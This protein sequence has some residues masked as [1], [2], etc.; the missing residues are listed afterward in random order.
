MS[1]SKLIS[2]GFPFL[3]VFIALFTFSS[4][5]NE[6]EIETGLTTINLVEAYNNPALINM[7]DFASEIEYISLE[8]SEE[9]FYRWV[10]LN[11]TLG[12]SIIL[13]KSSDRISLF[14]RKTGAYLRDIGYRG[15]DPEGFTNA[16]TELG[17]NAKNKTVYAKG[18]RFDL[19]EYS[20]DEGLLI[21]KIPGPKIEALEATLNSGS[22]TDVSLITSYGIIKDGLIAG[23]FM[24]MKG[25]EPYKLVVYD[26][27]GEI[28]NLYPNYL[29]YEKQGISIR[30]EYTDFHNYNDG[31]FF[32]ENFNDTVFNVG[33]DTLKPVLLYDLGEYSPPYA[34]QES[35][36]IEQRKEYMFVRNTLQSPDFVF[37]NVSF[38]EKEAYG[39][40]NRKTK[41]AKLSDPST[42][43][44]KTGY[45]NDIDN[46]VSFY[47]TSINE[48]GE[49]M[50]LIT[51]E[52][53]YEW[54]QNNPDKIASLPENL[55]ALQNIEPE[56]NP[57]IMIVKLK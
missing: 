57:V 53:V 3:A 51:A 55:Q 38:K 26:I 24:N 28:L 25:D 43:N 8:T 56:D 45:T 20:L 32:K 1:Q 48:A 10:R 5:S 19:Y 12:D 42:S 2:S 23:Y 15:D 44:S 31:L 41:E 27:N 4:C 46:F 47:P 6:K 14:D 34:E 49:M 9:T 54:F 36:S 33:V 16:R 7:S 22:F 37:Y 40:Y 50:G 35:M 29:S 52:E 30:I 17:V 13:M 39:Y 11:S 18:K 21:N